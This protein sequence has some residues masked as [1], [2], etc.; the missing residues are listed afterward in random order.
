MV[1]LDRSTTIGKMISS[2]LENKAELEDHVVHLLFSANRWE[3]KLVARYVFA[4]TQKF[5][6][7]QFSLLERVISKDV[8]I[9]QPHVPSV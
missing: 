3:A 1:L 7:F 9:S 5:P 8:W 4:S 6:V 2:Y